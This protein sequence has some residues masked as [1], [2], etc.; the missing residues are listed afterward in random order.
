[1]TIEQYKAELESLIARALAARLNPED[2]F[3]ITEDVIN[4][5]EITDEDEEENE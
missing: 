5:S 4:E 1:M 3:T 2:I